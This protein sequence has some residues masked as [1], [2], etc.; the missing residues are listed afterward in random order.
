VV[1]AVVGLLLNSLLVLLEARLL[2]WRATSE[3]ELDA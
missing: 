2:G 3:R 1:L